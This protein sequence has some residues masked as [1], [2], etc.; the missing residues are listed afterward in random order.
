MPRFIELTKT[1]G[2]KVLINI[3]TI[4]HIE[5]K[6]MALAPRV[7]GEGAHGGTWITL[8][9]HAELV[10]EPYEQIRAFPYWDA[11]HDVTGEEI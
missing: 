4:I 7:Q 11:V 9:H 10:Q 1:D 8:V 6:N 2:R 3:E 5:P